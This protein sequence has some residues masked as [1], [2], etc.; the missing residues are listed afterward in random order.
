MRFPE[1][2]ANFQNLRNEFSHV[3]AGDV[4]VIE[5]EDLGREDSSGGAA[6]R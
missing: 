6:E 4:S 3:L 2:A 1:A 5:E